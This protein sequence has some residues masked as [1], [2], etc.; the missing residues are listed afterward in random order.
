MSTS[1][2]VSFIK[3]HT[4]VYAVGFN[5]GGYSPDPD[6][7]S[8]AATLESARSILADMIDRFIDHESESIEESDVSEENRA[9]GWLWDGHAY[10]EAMMGQIKPDSTVRHEVGDDSGCS[11]YLEDSAGY[12]H[13]YWIDRS[14]IDG[15]F[16]PD[17]HEQLTADYCPEELADLINELERR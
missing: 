4:A 15:T 3:G 11:V 1:N 9:G 12:A 16:G 14:T 13:S 6:S 8:V 17:W 2:P 7:V 10:A 5:M